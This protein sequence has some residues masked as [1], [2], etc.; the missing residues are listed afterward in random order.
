M[1]QLKGDIL[2]LRTKGDRSISSTQ[3]IGFDLQSPS[4]GGRR[5]PVLSLQ[6]GGSNIEINMAF[7]PPETEFS[8][9]TFALGVNS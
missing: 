8:N 1:S 4:S 2:L 9:A 7:L 5:L 3:R 6:K